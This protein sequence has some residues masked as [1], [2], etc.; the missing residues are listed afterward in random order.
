MDEFY[1][2]C[3]EAALWGLGKFVE[4]SI[5]AYGAT[6]LCTVFAYGSALR[7]GKSLANLG[8]VAILLLPWA[9]AV[10]S[11]A[12]LVTKLGWTTLI[13]LAVSGCSYN[14]A[15]S[16]RRLHSPLSDWCNPSFR[17]IAES[18]NGNC[19]LVPD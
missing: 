16:E 1:Q 10:S 9:A 13:F 8:T 17:M 11:G 7:G 15:E 14:H 6:A 19:F 2:K 18:V 5:L 3:N 12:V 4:L